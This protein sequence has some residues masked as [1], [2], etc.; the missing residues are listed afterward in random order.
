MH[1]D[2]C[3][4]KHREIP[5]VHAGSGCARAGANRH[6]VEVGTLLRPWIDVEAS[7]IDNVKVD[8]T[9]NEQKYQ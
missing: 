4:F 9:C 1:R 8:S 6:P 5:K 2:S 3:I 7:D